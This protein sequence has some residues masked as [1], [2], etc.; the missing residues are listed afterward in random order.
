MN[1]S[2]ALTRAI[3]LAEARSDYWR[4]EL[5]KRHPNYP[6]IDISEPP[7]PPGPPVQALEEF[8]K[9]LPAEIVY[10]LLLV[11]YIGRGDYGTDDL[12]ERLAALKQQFAKPEFAVRQMLG[13]APLAAYLADGRLQLQQ[14]GINPDDVTASAVARAS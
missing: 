8:F 1:F 14:Q 4:V 13:K 12:R 7:D 6:L 3:E 11:M 5:P 9:Q 2:D 10:P